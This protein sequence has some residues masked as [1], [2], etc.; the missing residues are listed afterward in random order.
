MD[1]PRPTTHDPQPLEEFAPAK[2]NLGLAVT[3]RLENGYHALDTIFV[4]LNV[5]DTLT[6]EP[7]P[8]GIELEVSGANLGDP[9]DNLVY[10]AAQAYLEFIGHPGGVR[11]RLEKRLP[12]AAGLG[13]GSSDAAAALR[14]LVRLYPRSMNASS[15]HELAAKLGADVPFLVRGG[16]ARAS[17][18]GDLLETISIPETHVVLAN[19][20]VGITARE[21]YLGL[22]GRFGAPLEIDRIIQA[23]ERHEPPPYRNDLEIPVLEAYPIV[24]DVKDTLTAAGLFGVLMSGSGSTCFGLAR[25][26]RQATAAAEEI[27]LEQPTWWVTAARTA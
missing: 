6:L 19:P 17:G 20:G 1:F 4:T 7:I 13:G 18:V 25:D 16:A 3:G 11:M 14:G 24:Q 10:K 15:L 2:I 12:V 8:R 5:G 26:E 21:A 27:R 22:N 9:K 23:L